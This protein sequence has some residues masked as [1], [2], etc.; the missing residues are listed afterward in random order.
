MSIMKMRRW[1]NKGFDKVIFIGLAII[2]CVGM[3]SFFSGDMGPGKG[4][5]NAEQTTIAKVNG[6]EVGSNDFNAAYDFLR[7]ARPAQSALDDLNLQGEALSL[8]LYK[9]IYEKMANDQGVMPDEKTI[10][11]GIEKVEKEQGGNAL[12]VEFIKTQL[13]MKALIDKKKASIKVTEADALGVFEEVHLYRLI[14]A[15]KGKTAPVAEQN[16]KDIVQKIR[17]G[18]SFDEAYQKY[19]E[20]PPEAKKRKGE[21]AWI[22]KA[23]LQFDPNYKAIKAVATIGKGQI[24]DPIVFQNP[25]FPSSYGI[26]YVADSRMS[27]SF[28]QADFDKNKAA[29]ITQIQDNLA[30]Q[31]FQEEASK[32]MESAKVEMVEPTF[33]ALMRYNKEVQGQ[34]LEPAKRKQVQLE[35][36]ALL[37]KPSFAPLLNAYL[38]WRVANELRMDPA[39]KPTDRDKYTE[40]MIKSLEVLIREKGDP[41]LRTE[42]ASIFI[43]QKQNDKAVKQLEQASKSASIPD[44]ASLMIHQGIAN[45][46][47]QMRMKDKAMQE[48]ALMQAMTAKMPKS[49]QPTVTP[50]KPPTNK[51]EGR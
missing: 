38:K 20:D 51:P 26:F 37:E 21:L 17:A 8:A 9:P 22:G 18:M 44:R 2:L 12:S 41:Q 19:S 46:Y 39:L 3:I 10:Q 32:L 13:I 25:A 28:K 5:Q 48:V 15:G 29:I 30:S 11:K 16:A 23:Q 6:L 33:N 45:A 50:Q 27:K 40:T 49:P 43:E 4:N 24:S 47:L 1:V 31:Q 7:N 42:L 14:I 35:L 36:M 34:I